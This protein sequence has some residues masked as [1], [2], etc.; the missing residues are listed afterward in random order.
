MGGALGHPALSPGRLDQTAATLALLKQSDPVTTL[1]ERMRGEHAGDSSANYGCFAIA[2]IQCANHSDASRPGQ[3]MSTANCRAPA[4]RGAPKK[5]MKLD[6][7]ICFLFP[8]AAAVRYWW[9][10][11]AGREQR[12]CQRKKPRS[13]TIG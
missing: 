8:S 1:V 11:Q 3:Q 12:L 13:R 10:V 5:T 4:K 6:T 2:S 7:F 9:R